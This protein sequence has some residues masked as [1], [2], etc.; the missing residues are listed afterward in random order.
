MA[1]LEQVGVGDAALARLEQ[2]GVG[3]AARAWLERMGNGCLEQVE[4]R[5][6]AHL[7]ASS[8]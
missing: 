5:K 2:V 1:Q 8:A 7:S 6:G 3:D 4:L